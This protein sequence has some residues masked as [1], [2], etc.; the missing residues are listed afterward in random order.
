[1]SE[2]IRSNAEKVK[3]EKGSNLEQKLA[4]VGWSLFFIWVGITLLMKID[5]GT[6]LLGVGIITLGM[7]WVR[8]NNSLSIEGFWIVIGILFVLGGIWDL[9]EITF[10]MVPVLIILGGAA[11]L[12]KTIKGKS[13]QD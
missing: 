1:M 8:K 3:A 11:L 5:S 4:G 12:I 9:F 2:E 6:G 7:Q 10:S 13:Q